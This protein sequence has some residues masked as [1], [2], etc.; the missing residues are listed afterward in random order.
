MGSEVGWL[1][2][3]V[4]CFLS[5]RQQRTRVG[6]CYSSWK[7]VNAG[8]PQGTKLGPLLFL[9]MAND[10]KPSE[11]TVK[12]VDDT[13]VWE[14]L[15]KNTQ[16]CIPSTVAQ[17]AEWASR[18]NMKLNPTKTKE[19]VVNF[20]KMPL[21]RTDRYKNSFRLP[22]S[23]V[24]FKIFPV[25]SATNDPTFSQCL[26]PPTTA[27]QIRLFRVFER[28]IH[29]RMSPHFEK[30]FHR[31]VFAY[32]KYHGCDTAL[33]SLTEQWKKELDS[34]KTIGLVSM[35]LSKAFDSLPHDLI[36]LKLQKCGADEKTVELINRPM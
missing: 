23:L 29:T 16:S 12:Y 6:H 27:S 24:R 33:L 11:N 28:L 8:V 35:D 5:D 34:H 14:V 21:C 31:Y 10:L 4:A 7:F 26:Q 20:S 32:R 3:W 15:S 2:N 13:T 30:I 1:I 19:V 9:L 25:L 18:N 36:V 22:P 17:C